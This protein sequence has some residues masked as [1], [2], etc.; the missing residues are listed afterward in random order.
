M[1]IFELLAPRVRLTAENVLLRQQLVI[2]R[3]ATRRP[4]LKSW[5]R[6]FPSAFAVRW[7]VL[8]DA[9]AIVKPA[10]LLRWHRASWRWLVVAAKVETVAGAPGDPG[11]IARVDSPT[12]VR[13]HESERFLGPFPPHNRA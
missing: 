9:V 11:R 12:L 2:L 1:Q 13:P 7:S 10:T 4:R 6:R 3:R 8:R 5:E